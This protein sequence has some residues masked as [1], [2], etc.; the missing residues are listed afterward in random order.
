MNTQ[1]IKLA[2][3]INLLNQTATTLQPIIAIKEV[4]RSAEGVGSFVSASVSRRRQIDADNEAALLEMN[5]EH[6]TVHVDMINNQRT[7]RQYINGFD[8]A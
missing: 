4:M 7:Q 1:K 8:V 5:Y 6:C 2:L 3:T